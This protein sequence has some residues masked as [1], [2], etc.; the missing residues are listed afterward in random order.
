MLFISNLSF[1][2]KLRSLTERR[3]DRFSNIGSR[4]NPL[5]ELL[6]RSR[7]VRDQH[8]NRKVRSAPSDEDILIR[9]SR[10]N[11]STEGLIRPKFNPDKHLFREVRS[12]PSEDESFIRQTRFNPS[13]ESFIRPKFY[14]DQH[15]LRKERSAPSEEESK[16]E[17]AKPK[18]GVGKSKNERRENKKRLK[19][20]NGWVV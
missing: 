13:K 9:L 18:K 14:P 4:F 2:E 8:L 17:K 10:F 19:I 5:D 11:P 3:S 16:K 15:L 20:W 7:F 6:I 1:I 12:A